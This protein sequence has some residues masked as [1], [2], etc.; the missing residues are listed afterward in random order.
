M[1][2]GS[3]FGKLPIAKSGQKVRREKTEIV[4]YKIA[5]RSMTPANERGT[6]MPPSA[7]KDMK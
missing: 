1:I 4:I 3:L 5:E 7:K 6:Q 2:F